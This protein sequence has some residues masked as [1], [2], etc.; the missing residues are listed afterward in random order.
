MVLLGLSAMRLIA[1]TVTH[2][3]GPLKMQGKC[4][5]QRGAGGAAMD[6]GHPLS[7]RCHAPA[8]TLRVNVQRPGQG[9]PR[10]DDKS[11][12]MGAAGL[13]EQAVQ[14]EKQQ[15]GRHM[16]VRSSVVAGVALLLALATSVA[17]FLARLPP[18]TV[19]SAGTCWVPSRAC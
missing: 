3:R 2:T 12:E 14:Y 17:A 10:S 9:E 4:R 6:A 1:K 16:S 5:R 8:T 18:L 19:R 7:Q 15:K 11:H 13:K